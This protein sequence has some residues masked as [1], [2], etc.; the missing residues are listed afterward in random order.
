LKQKKRSAALADFKE[1][2]SKATDAN[3]GTEGETDCVM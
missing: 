2:V 1:V 3:D